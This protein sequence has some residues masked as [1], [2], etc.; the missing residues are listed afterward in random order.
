MISEENPLRA[1]LPRRRAPQPCAMVIF[2]ATGDLTRRKLIPALFHLAGEG[3]LPA[4]LAIVGFARREGSDEQL[5][6]SF[7]RA[8]GE[9]AQGELWERFAQ[10]IFYYRGE[11]GDPAAYVGLRELLA[12][13][14]RERGTAG[15]RLFYLSTPPDVAAE[16][17]R[18][19]GEA[20]LVPPPRE[21]GP[22]ARLV[23]EKPFGHDLA[24]AVELNRQLAAVFD[25]SQIFRI[26]HYLGKETV[27][28][29]LVLRFANQLF[30][31]LWNQKYV[32]H[33]QITVSESL[34]VEGRGG[35]FEGAGI[36]RD[37]VQN[38]L[39]Q[40]LC[41]VGMEPPA[42]LEANPVRDE[43]VQLLHS[44]R[45]IRPAEANEI[46]VRGQYG[47]GWVNGEEV[48][49]YRSEPDV[50]PASTVET[51]VALRLWIDN[52][53]WAGVP[54]YLRAGK[55]L[56]KRVTEIAVEF[57][58][59]P[60]I[61]FNRD[62]DAPLAPNVLAIRIQPDEGISLRFA[63]KV[64]GQAVRIE[65]VKMEFSYGA[66]FGTEPPEA[67]ER[68][69]LD[70]LLGDSTLFTRR[71]EV[72]AAWAIVDPILKGWREGE[73][74]EFPNYRA[75]TWGPEAADAFI[76]ADGRRWRRL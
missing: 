1:G 69:L 64:P 43:K 7:R 30:E 65:P 39:L 50:D 74:H 41:L 23:V 14:D 57:K 53:R 2:G 31:P 73:A 51:Y 24:S 21:S 45:P 68:L 46:T 52:W 3:L 28:N 34:G 25:E 20:G 47:P 17:A 70:A 15:N 56:P 8:L 29:L 42:V 6:E 71:D 55:R 38:H 58:S 72:E 27:Q 49:G 36:L 22:W 76:E 5:R 12:R 4:S 48:P 19:L 16:V 37:M 63:A 61:L 13:L 60:R 66:A 26:D 59:V 40:L 32:D 18:C 75:G 67:Y 11:Y 10:S 62:P 44:V 33:V 35:Y 9:A 54:F